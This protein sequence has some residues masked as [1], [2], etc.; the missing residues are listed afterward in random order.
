MHDTTNNVTVYGCNVTVV[1]RNDLVIGNNVN[2]TG[3]S[4]DVESNIVPGTVVVV[5]SNDRA[6][7][8]QFNA[9][10]GS[11]ITCQNGPCRPIATPANP[12][13]ILAGNHTVVANNTVNGSTFT[14]GS[15]SHGPGNTVYVQGAS[16]DD[17]EG[18]QVATANGFQ[19]FAGQHLVVKGNRINGGNTSNPTGLMGY[20]TYDANTHTMGPY[21]NSNSDTV[22][23]NVATDLLMTGS[24]GDTVTGNVQY[25][26]GGPPGSSGIHFVNDQNSTVA[27]N[28]ASLIAIYASSNT[29]LTYNNATG[30]PPSPAGGNA[31]A[32]R[33]FSSR[34][35][36]HRV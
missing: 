30:A 35:D 33:D 5:G 21:H 17:V 3:S 6:I 11:G 25:A 14:F 36:K 19:V 27:N 32:H 7:G 9:A 12:N 15:I 2:V 4:D 16:S 20:S 34:S 26:G 18:N 8:N 24:V 22:V 31:A 10:S 28:R 29:T 1:G 13:F 23:N